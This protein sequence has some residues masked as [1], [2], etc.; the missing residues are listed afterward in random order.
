MKSLAL[1]ETEVVDF[2]T[3]L[4]EDIRKRLKTH[5]HKSDA[6]QD[7]YDSKLFVCKVGQFTYLG[8]SDLNV[9]GGIGEI[10]SPDG[11]KLVAEFSGAQLNGRVDFTSPDMSFSG[12]FVQGSLKMIKDLFHKQYPDETYTGGVQNYK[13]HGFGILIELI[14]GRKVE[15][16]GKFVNGLKEGNCQM[17]SDNYNFLGQFSSNHRCGRGRLNTQECDIFGNWI[18][19]RV[20]DC[21]QLRS[22]GTIYRGEIQDGKR[23]GLG[24]LEKEGYSYS[25]YF[26]NDLKQGIAQE[27]NGTEKYC[28]EFRGNQRQGF[29]SSVNSLTKV[30]YTGMWGDGNRKGLGIYK[31]EKVIIMGEWN[32]GVLE[33]KAITR[34]AKGEV[35]FGEYIND[36]LVHNIISKDRMKEFS[37]LI[38]DQKF[39]ERA[40][41]MNV[42]LATVIGKL[43]V[44]IDK[45]KDAEEHF[46]TSVDVFKVDEASSISRLK[47]FDQ[48]KRFSKECVT[49]MET[50]VKKCTGKQIENLGE[51]IEG[52]DS[53]SLVLVRHD[54]SDRIADTVQLPTRKKA[55][56][57][58]EDRTKEKIRAGPFSRTKQK[59]ISIEPSKDFQ[60]KKLFL[61][62]YKSYL[63]PKIKL[64]KK[65]EVE[66][67]LPSSKVSFS[68]K[69]GDEVIDVAINF[70]KVVISDIEMETKR[71]KK[72]EEDY[73]R[74]MNQ[75]LLETKKK[76][77]FEVGNVVHSFRKSLFDKHKSKSE[78]QAERE[79]DLRR[80]RVEREHLEPE[81]PE[82]QEKAGEQLQT[83]SIHEREDIAGVINEEKEESDDELLQRV[84][85][86]IANLLRSESQPPLAIREVEPK[87]TF[88]AE[89]GSQFHVDPAKMDRP[90]ST[91]SHDKKI[92]PKVRSAQYNHHRKFSRILAK[93]KDGNHPSIKLTPTEMLAFRAYTTEQEDVKQAKRPK[94]VRRD[95]FIGDKEKVMMV[96]DDKK[97]VNSD[98]TDQSLFLINPGSIISEGDKQSDTSDSQDSPNAL[99]C[100]LKTFLVP[101]GADNKPRVTDVAKSFWK[102]DI[103]D[104]LDMIS[105]CAQVL[106]HYLSKS[107]F[108]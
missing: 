74:L 54:K 62:E 107:N 61:D 23:Q 14:D 35:S 73:E 108:R 69:S 17:K 60:F 37:A 41:K 9:K 90:A 82:K 2:Y 91:D 13:P 6:L 71:Q 18:N 103:D 27:S 28:G 64:P 20:S 3:V 53:S 92:R 8:Q 75:T 99:F 7:K 40:S 50:R 4:L 88:A 26:F 39:N 29:G 81:E 87:Q 45:A 93:G 15:T 63:D 42:A 11:R 83:P 24:I 22:K 72:A 46:K 48:A 67:N 56:T 38:Q 33:G 96:F 49:T 84:S 78:R 10:C 100:N 32:N 12:Q 59:T 65:E 30:S 1:I 16:R 105:D 79:R 5:Q 36:Q 97:S 98:L 94:K 31:D 44:V 102:S 19:D 58:E 101:P 21:G 76:S 85:P 95:A 52:T 51:V 55:M 57:Y 34:S 43:K 106:K 80:G 86:S 77:F 70:V 104:I 68:S 89:S 66:E 47:H 25:G